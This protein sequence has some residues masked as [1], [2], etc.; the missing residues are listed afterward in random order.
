[1]AGRKMLEWSRDLPAW[2]KWGAD[3]RGDT[4]VDVDP[5]VYFPK[6][7]GIMKKVAPELDTDSPTQNML[8]VA[9]WIMQRRLKKLMYDD[10][11]DYLRLHI[12]RRPAWAEKNFP[13]GEPINKRKFYKKLGI[14][15]IKVDP[16][17]E[18][19]DW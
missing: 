18:D 17:P 19:I 4:R 8:Q 6:F 2:A 1:M 3:E 10:G 14:D 13:V 5:D 7:L 9:T 15:K 12:L 11:K 16:E